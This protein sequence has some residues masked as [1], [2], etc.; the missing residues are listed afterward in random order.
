MGFQAELETY[1]GP[2]DLMLTLIKKQKLDIMEL[3]MDLLTSQFLDYILSLEKLNLEIESTY[4]SELALLIEYKAKKLLPNETL[5]LE[6]EEDP[7]QRLIQR[8]LEYQKFKDASMQLYDSYLDRLNQYGKTIN[9]PSIFQENVVEDFKDVEI[10]D[11]TKAISK[12]FK[13]LSLTKPLITKYTEKEISIEDITLE[14]R[15]KLRFFPQE[16]NFLELVKD[17]D[18]IQKYVLT[19]LAVLDLIRTQHLRFRIDDQDDIY[20]GVNHGK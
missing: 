20:L 9:D 11:L 1:D 19:F 18:H 5:E 17:C 4:L 3:D 6:V 2:L 16:F 12:L 7:K 10:N 13:R 8:L 15:S 14:I